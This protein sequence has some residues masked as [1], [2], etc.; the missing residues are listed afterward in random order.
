[1]T[2]LKKRKILISKETVALFSE[3]NDTEWCGFDSLLGQTPAEALVLTHTISWPFQ[4]PP[5]K[6]K[7]ECKESD[8]KTSK[9]ICYAFPIPTSCA[10]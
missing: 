5:V 7:P 8:S 4:T 9:R 2:F 10:V 6:K 1:M 3:V